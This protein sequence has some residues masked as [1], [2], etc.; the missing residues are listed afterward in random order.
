MIVFPSLEVFVGK[1]DPRTEAGQ[2]EEAKDETAGG[3]EGEGYE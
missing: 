1:F 3:Q 2:T